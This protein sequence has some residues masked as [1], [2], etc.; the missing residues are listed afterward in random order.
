[1]T[2]CKFTK[3]CMMRCFSSMKMWK[4]AGNSFLIATFNLLTF[5]QFYIKKGIYVLVCVCV[6]Q[7]IVFSKTCKS[8]G[9]ERRGVNVSPLV[10]DLLLKV[11]IKGIINDSFF[12]KPV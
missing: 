8:G 10:L 3:R 7:H 9:K 2:L 5:L 11:I 4:D 1:M 12:L 6:W